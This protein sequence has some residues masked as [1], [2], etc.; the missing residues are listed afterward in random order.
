LTPTDVPTVSPTTIV[1]TDSPTTL[2]PTVSPTT[3]IPCYNY[4][5]TNTGVTADTLFWEDCVTGNPLST[6]VSN[7]QTFNICAR[8]FSV[9]GGTF[10][11]TETTAC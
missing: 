6:S 2:T 1:P 11:I 10:T 9:T 7:G 4:D 3:A 5:A 8:R